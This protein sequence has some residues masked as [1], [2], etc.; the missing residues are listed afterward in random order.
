LQAAQPRGRVIS[1]SPLIY[2]F[3]F[4][5]QI[6]KPVDPIILGSLL[7][8]LKHLTTVLQNQQ[9]FVQAWLPS[10]VGLTSTVAALVVGLLSHKSA[11]K[12]I[13]TTRSI[14][15]AQIKSAEVIAKSQLENAKDITVSQIKANLLAASRKEW[16]ENL[17]KEI[18]ETCT[19]ANKVHRKQAVAST[20]QHQ[21]IENERL[22]EVNSAL[23]EIQRRGIYI[24]LLLNKTEPEH[25]DFLLKQR[26][27][28][29]FCANGEI[30]MNKWVDLQ[31]QYLE[32]AKTILKI[33][34]NKVKN[35]S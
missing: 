17:R 10:I 19:L 26:T 22:K 30:D 31:W 18:T 35:L 3:F 9:S 27:F 13:E 2:C 24:E 12:Q 14:A 1:S 23:E 33:E 28:I 34:W 8:Q 16:I 20:S 5:E 4:K 32:A 29:S 6:M 25:Q 11:K 7:E 15:D 21:Q